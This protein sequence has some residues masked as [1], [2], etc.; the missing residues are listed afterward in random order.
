MGTIMAHKSSPAIHEG[1]RGLGNIE[2]QLEALSGHTS[3]V[4]EVAERVNGTL[5]DIIPIW[6][7]TNT[8]YAISCIER[9]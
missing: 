4:D 9:L 3:V 1:R 8:K 5:G 6:V 2:S 7:R